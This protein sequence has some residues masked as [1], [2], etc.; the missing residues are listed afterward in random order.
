MHAAPSGGGIW[1]AGDDI[2]S[3]D[4]ITLTG[5]TVTANNAQYGGA[6]YGSGGGRMLVRQSPQMMI[7]ALSCVPYA[8]RMCWK[9]LCMS[10]LILWGDSGRAFFGRLTIEWCMCK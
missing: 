10:S 8:V 2:A 4:L 9:P 7:S 6:L 1:F 3:S 5:C